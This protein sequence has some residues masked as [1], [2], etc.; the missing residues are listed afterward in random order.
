MNRSS[1]TVHERLLRS[2]LWKRGFRF[3][4]DDRELVGRPDV[5]FRTERVAVFCD[6]DF[7]HGRGWRK[8]SRKLQVGTNASYWVQKI[9]T[10]RLR[11]RR[12][13]RALARGG[14]QVVRLWETDILKDPAASVA[15]VE[16]LL[17]RRRRDANPPTR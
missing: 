7:W 4:K 14:W 11:D 16:A 5:V 2:T 13:D 12:N 10:N 17:Y 9:R 15:A 3:R 1:E 6:G 8:L